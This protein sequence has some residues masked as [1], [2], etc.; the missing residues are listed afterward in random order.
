M[1]VIDQ[2]NWKRKAIF[3]HF[4]MSSNPFY[5]C[6]FNVDVTN[7]YKYVKEHKL[8]FYYTM[9]HCVIK[10]V[11]AVENFHYAIE[12]DDVVYLDHRDPSFTDMYDDSEC[13]HIVSMPFID[14]IAE[15]NKQARERN[16]AQ[17]FFLDYERENNALAYISTLP[18]V[19]LTGITNEFDYMNPDMKNDSNPRI[20]WGKF[21]DKNGRKVLGLSMEVNHRFI[22][23]IHISKFAKEL[24]KIINE[25]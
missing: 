2:N 10:A 11:N 22:D 3:D 12:G 23:G 5:M 15:F 24:E 6:T 1:K 9:M 17:T 21:N 19:E 13:F 16:L 4:S 18:G 7:V 25:L 14:D 20:C 8:S